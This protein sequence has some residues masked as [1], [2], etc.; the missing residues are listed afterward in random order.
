[1]QSV[2][3]ALLGCSVFLMEKSFYCFSFDLMML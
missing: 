2:D 3:L 1:M